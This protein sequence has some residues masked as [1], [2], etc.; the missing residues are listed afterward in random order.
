MSEERAVVLSDWPQPAVVAEAE[1]RA[2]E[3]DFFMRYCNS[4]DKTVIVH[5]PMCHSDFWC[6][7]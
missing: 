4:D 7:K 1:I 5:F 3:H 6:T 2:D